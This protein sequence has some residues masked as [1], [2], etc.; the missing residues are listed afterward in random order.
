MN[1][2]S[3]CDNPI[4]AFMLVIDTMS[5]MDTDGVSLLSLTS[6]II[7]LLAYFANVKR[8]LHSIVMFQQLYARMEK[9]NASSISV[10][11]KRRHLNMYFF[12]LTHYSD[13]Y[14]YHYHYYCLDYC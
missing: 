13:D 1:H 10:Q 12:S 9:E 6:S 2:L 8:C 3:L 7:W 14:Y 4:L 11:Y 5:I